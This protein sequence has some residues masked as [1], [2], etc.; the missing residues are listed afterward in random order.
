MTCRA[1]GLFE[2]VVTPTTEEDVVE[3]ESSSSPDLETISNKLEQ[4]KQ[5]ALL[6]R[7]SLVHDTVQK[8]DEPNIMPEENLSK[9][10]EIKQLQQQNA[11]LISQ[12]TDISER[13]KCQWDKLSGLESQLLNLRSTTNGMAEKI[14]AIS[15]W[16]TT[17]QHMAGLCI[18]R[19]NDLKI[20]CCTSPEF[21][22]YYRGLSADFDHDLKVRV[23]EKCYRKDQQQITQ[24]LN[25]TK[26]M[27]RT[28]TDLLLH[29]CNQLE[30]FVSKGSTD[31]RI[32]ESSKTLLRCGFYTIMHKFR[33]A[34]MQTKEHKKAE[35]I[36]L[37]DFKQFE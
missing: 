27:I 21:G 18:E 15:K 20:S 5:R 1:P 34:E 7:Q 37:P 4:M 36:A 19:Y 25:N 32:Y 13:L 24:R 26:Q 33:V 16:K 35:P 28:S 8:P 11:K 22:A 17:T 9:H 10:L 29:H 2:K 14:N 3:E 31:Q 23:P 6:L 30:Q 12:V